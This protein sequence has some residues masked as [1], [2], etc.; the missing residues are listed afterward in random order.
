MHY[1]DKQQEDRM[2]YWEK[3]NHSWSE[4][5]S[6]VILTPSQRIRNLFFYIQ[7]IGHFKVHIPYFTERENLPSYLIKFTLA[8][9]GLLTYEGENYTLKA[10]DLFFIDC[11]KYQRYQTVSQ[12]PWE[13]DWIH[14]NGQMAQL[15]YA[16][17]MKDGSPVFHTKRPAENKIHQLITELIHLQDQSNARTD[18]Q[19]SVLIHE[20]LNELILQKYHLDFSEEDIPVYIHDLQHFLDEHFRETITLADLEDRFHLNKY[21]LS[22]EFSKFIGTPPID[23]L[24]SKKI[25]Y[26]KDLLR[27]TEF[28]VQDISSEIGIDNFAYFSRLFKTKTGLSPREFRNFN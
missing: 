9:E 18:F 24:I 7:E 14:L 25:S 19:T 2:N 27:Y 5:S 6:R 20:L 3:A 13:M 12:T 4:D 1:L 16:E 28:S 21:Q 26:A 11:Q 17:F 15:F 23:Y 10:G 8:G 22:K